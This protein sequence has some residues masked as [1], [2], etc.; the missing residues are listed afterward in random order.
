MLN[1]IGNLDNV[2]KN[3]KQLITIECS[4]KEIQDLA[5]LRGECNPFGAKD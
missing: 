5:R 3:I 1:R 4:T 2:R